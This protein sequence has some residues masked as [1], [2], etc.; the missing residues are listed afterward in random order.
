MRLSTLRLTTTRTAAAR[1]EGNRF[2]LLPFPDVGALVTTGEGWQHHADAT[3]EPLGLPHVPAVT[4]PLTTRL[5][6]FTQAYV[7][8]ATRAKELDHPHPRTPQLLTTPIDRLV[9][10]GD[11]VHLAPAA[12]IQWGVELGVV[13]GQET[14]RVPVAKALQSIAGYTTVNTI[15]APGWPAVV[16]IGPQLVTPDELPPGAR[17]LTLTA[18][19]DGRPRQKA[20]TSDLLFDVA[21]LITR[22]SARTTLMPGDLITTGTPATTHAGPLGEGSRL[23]VCITGIGEL[24]TTITHGNAR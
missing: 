3:G 24:R 9:G 6:T 1:V 10:D 13:I 21:T 17:G 18:T 12:D 16:A 4:G 15:A 7:N 22:I 5:T 2:T 20:N 19:L 23:H 14:S 8:Y 11:T